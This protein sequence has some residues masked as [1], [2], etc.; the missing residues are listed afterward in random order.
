MNCFC[1]IQ[2]YF[3]IT[4]RYKRSPSS[5][6]K[7]T[8]MLVPHLEQPM[9]DWFSLTHVIWNGLLAEAPKQLRMNRS[10][11]LACWASAH[12]LPLQGYRCFTSP[13]LITCC[14]QQRYSAWSCTPSATPRGMKGRKG[15]AREKD[16]QK[17]EW[18]VWQLQPPA[19]DKNQQAKVLCV[20]KRSSS[21]KT[22][23]EVLSPVE[24]VTAEVIGQVEALF[25]CEV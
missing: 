13:S 3:R 10:R 6:P 2:N 1:Q 23:F 14:S 5:S 8:H 22:P 21:S 9:C 17:E 12:F 15:T 25:S 19:V 4:F 11:A 16:L 18:K 24:Q 7:Q 20:G